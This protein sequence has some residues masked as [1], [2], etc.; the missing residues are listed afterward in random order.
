M[1]LENR[2]ERE[3]SLRVVLY[4]VPVLYTGRGWGVLFKAKKRQKN[5]PKYFE[6]AHAYGCVIPIP[7]GQNLGDGLPK[8]IDGGH[9]YVGK[10]AD[11]RIPKILRMSEICL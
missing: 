11:D 3:P 7:N 9:L 1:W 2:S 6:D 10:G 8:R 5:I 4:C